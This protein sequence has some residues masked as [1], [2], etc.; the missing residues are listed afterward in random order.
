VELDFAL[1]V[2][3]FETAE[4]DLIIE[5]AEP[6]IEGEDDPDDELP[7]APGPRVS[8]VDDLWLLGRHRI[9]C[10]NALNTSSYSA[11]MARPP[12]RHGFYGTLPTTSKLQGTRASR[13]NP[14]PRFQD[15]QRGDERVPIH[16][17]SGAGLH[18]TCA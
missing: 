1:D 10:G 11:L 16:G 6:A 18:I 14:A 15:G 9:Y 5:G 8:Q 3:G 4:I 13:N 17:F 7:R 2:T 12:S